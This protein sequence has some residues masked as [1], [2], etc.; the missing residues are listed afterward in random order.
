MNVQFYREISSN[1]A[2]WK[3]LFNSFDKGIEEIK[4]I[5]SFG[6]TLSITKPTGF[7]LKKNDQYI[8]IGYTTKKC[9]FF[10]TKILNPFMKPY[11]DNKVASI[12]L[13][14]FHNCFEQRMKL[15][16]KLDMSTLPGIKYFEL[17]RKCILAV[18]VQ[19]G[20][21]VESLYKRE[22]LLLKQI[23]NC[24][25]KYYKEIT[26]GRD[27]QKIMYELYH[28]KL[29]SINEIFLEVYTAYVTKMTYKWSG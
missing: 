10:D 27:M 8:A 29:P 17:S 28:D 15:L 16:E 18:F 21:D 13:H 11:E 25:L 24:Q 12:N 19:C 20:V 23:E 3:S 1:I 22:L 26:K 9:V 6:Q 5:D 7:L 14:N 4:I 2:D